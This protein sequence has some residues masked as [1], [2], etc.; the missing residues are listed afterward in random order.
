MVCVF[1]CP[2]CSSNMTFNA[3]KQKLECTVCGTEVAVEEYDAA[4][5]TLDGGQECGDDMSSYVCP[6]C[7]AEM[8]T[9]NLQVTCNCSYCGTG[10]AV[11]G[12]GEKKVMPEKVIPFSVTE[13]QAFNYF[14]KWWMD[15]DTL[16]EFNRN[17]MKF[18][19]HPMYL[20]V[21]LLDANVHTDM[22]AIVSRMENKEKVTRRY[23]IRK[24]IKSK[25]NGVPT[26]ASYH[27]SSTRFQGIEPYDYSKLQDFSAA[28][29]SGY[30]AEQYSVEMRDVV[31]KT[32]KRVLDFGEDQ[33]RTY[34]LGSGVGIS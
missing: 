8:L 13:E 2:G 15:H 22:S 21:W 4:E 17:K 3:E 34:I 26:N 30:P 33:C 1:R 9:E 27:F 24:A 6:G 23:L 19:M 10:M 5:I 25:F 14:C 28:Y 16:P 7:G 20:P 18:E 12:G 29:L 31:P 11:F 32:I